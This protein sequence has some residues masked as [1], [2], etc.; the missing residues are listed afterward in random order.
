MVFRLFITKFDV[1]SYRSLGANSNLKHIFRMLRICLY[2]HLYLHFYFTFENCLCRRSEYSQFNSSQLFLLYLLF[3]LAD[4]SLLYL[5]AHL[6][7]IFNYRI[8]LR[9]L[10][11]N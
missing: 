5:L 4:N 1:S 9:R 7:A 11:A 10:Y 2:L 6:V 3:Y 8:V